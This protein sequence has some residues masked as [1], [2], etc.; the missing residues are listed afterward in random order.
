MSRRV[1][2]VLLVGWAGGQ[3]LCFA[4]AARRYLYGIPRSPLGP[5]LTRW[6]PVLPVWGMVAVG[7]A[8]SCAAA[9]HLAAEVQR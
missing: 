1:Q 7:A 9:F 5:D 4:Q 8:A 2:L 6:S 3:S